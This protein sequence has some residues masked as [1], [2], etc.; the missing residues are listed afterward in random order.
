MTNRNENFKMLKYRK[1]KLAIVALLAIGLAAA[2][3]LTAG[4]QAATALTPAAASVSAAVPSFW[5]F[6][7]TCGGSSYAPPG[8][9]LSWGLWQ[10]TDCPPLIGSGPNPR[11]I[12]NWHV[13]FFSSGS[14]CTQVIGWVQPGYPAFSLLPPKRTVF[15]GGCG[16]SGSVS[17]PWQ[18]VAA[19]AQLRAASQVLTGVP[20]DW[21]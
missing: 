1:A 2:P 9:G 10:K 12:Y 7:D 4:A 17:V 19:F 20:V 15:S 16:R 14:V 18:G 6:G 5:I 21:S 8:F 3:A 13:P 11:N